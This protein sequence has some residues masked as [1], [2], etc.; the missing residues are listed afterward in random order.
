MSTLTALARVIALAAGRAQQIATVRH[1]HLHER[2]FVF[3]PLALAG[4]ANAPLAALVGDDRDAPRLRFVAQPRNRDQ[5]F[6]FAAAVASDVL[7]YVDEFAVRTEMV[8]VDRGRDSR[9]RYVNAPQI[10]V[11]NSAGVRFLRLLGRSTRFRRTDGEYAVHPS[12]PQL[13]RWLTFF[14]ERTEHPGSYL[15]LAATDALSL[16]WATGQSLVEDQNLAALLGWIAPSGGLTG[17]EVAALAEDPLTWPP[18]GPATDP[19]FDNEVLAPLIESGNLTALEKALATQLEPTWELMWQAVDLLRTL[20]AGT[21][22][23]A[24]WDA[25]K[26]AYT[27]YVEYLR[28]SGLPQPRRDSAVAAARRLN[29]LEREQASYAAQR[30]LDDP[31][32]MAEYRLAGEAFVGTV[33]AVDPTRVQGTGRSRKLR[34]HITVTTSDP[35]RLALGC[36]VSA[37]TRPGQKATIVEVNGG[38]VTLELAGAMGRAL[39]PAAGSLPELG[40]RICYSSIVEGYRPPDSFPPRED[41]PWTHGGPPVEYTPTDEDAYEEWS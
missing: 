16:H 28:E 9:T 27:S 3:I 12:V 26:D 18:A 2:P 30:G 6:A 41:T 4:E 25:D 13:G 20:P 23:G 17:P 29:W 8:S 21:R 39:T 31:L 10:L 24:R 38:D 19:T 15:L 22:V 36:E 5:R 11:P 14:A 1:I 33:T 34:P 37:P 35:I 40:E 7:S 32:V